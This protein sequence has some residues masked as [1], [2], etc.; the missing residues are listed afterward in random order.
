MKLIS[1]VEILIIVEMLPIVQ[2]TR[3]PSRHN[4]SVENVIAKPIIMIRQSVVTLLLVRKVTLEPVLVLLALI[5]MNA[6]PVSVVLIL[7][8]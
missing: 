4:L 7:L 8:V 1:N 2:V 5:L 6:K 3:P